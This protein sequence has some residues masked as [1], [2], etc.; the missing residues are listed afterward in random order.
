MSY[1]VYRGAEKIS[2]SAKEAMLL[3]SNKLAVSINLLRKRRR[4]VMQEMVTKRMKS[5]H[6]P[7][8]FD[9]I[10][11]KGFFLLTACFK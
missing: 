5:D 8:Y 7:A 1:S 9:T 10:T 3:L 11:V 2:C 4:D 6:G